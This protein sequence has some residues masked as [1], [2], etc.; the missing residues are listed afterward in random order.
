[1]IKETNHLTKQNV[2]LFFLL[3]MKCELI[4]NNPLVLL[5]SSSPQLRVQF[6]SRNTRRDSSHRPPRRRHHDPLPVS[7]PSHR[8]VQVK[9]QP[10]P[11]ATIEITGWF[12]RPSFGAKSTPVPHQ[13]DL[14]VKATRRATHRSPRNRSM[15]SRV[16]PR[17]QSTRTSAR[18]N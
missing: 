14:Q 1:M 10:R 4:L 3:L 18:P 7:S 11:L 16:W 5:S 9:T 15:S 13:L 17:T 6:R 2:S 8:R 12:R